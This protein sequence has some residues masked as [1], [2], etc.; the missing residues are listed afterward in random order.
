VPDK[1]NFSTHAVA[2]HLASRAL[3]QATSLELL[4]R[5]KRGESRALNVLVARYVPFLRRLA[6]GRIPRWARTSIDTADLVQDTLM[7]TL[8]RLHSFEPRG[9]GAMRA[10]LR[11]ALQNRI[12]SVRRDSMRRPQLDVLDD[13]HHDQRPTPLELAMTANDRARYESALR[14]L[15]ADDRQAVVGRVELGYSYEQLAAVLG[16]ATPDAARVAVR[17][18]LLRLADAMNESGRR[19]AEDQLHQSSRMTDTGQST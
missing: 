13:V 7:N 12:H 18:A 2:D 17:R 10:Y 15:R 8:R 16:K 3:D 14:E 6:H 11:Q 19:R 9:N 4:R 5:A 1:S